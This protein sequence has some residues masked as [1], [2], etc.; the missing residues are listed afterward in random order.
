MICVYFMG[1]V[2]VILFYLYGIQ[3]VRQLSIWMTDTFNLK[4]S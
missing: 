1:G 3:L 2:I 4:S